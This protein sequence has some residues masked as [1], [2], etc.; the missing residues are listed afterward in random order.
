VSYGIGHA[1]TSVAAW[2][3]LF[4]VLGGFSL[5]WGV[6]VWVFL[7]NS[8]VT[9]WYMSD[10]E[11]YICLQRIRDN[12]TGVEE[13]KHVKWYQVIECLSDPRTWLLFIFGMF[14]H[15]LLHSLLVH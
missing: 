5:I 14:P 8:P 13:K 15:A 2:R 11:K 10:R 9:C 6:F 7:P 3:L 4:L 1:H 12:N